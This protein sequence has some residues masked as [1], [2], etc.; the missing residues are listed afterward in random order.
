MGRRSRD[1]WT[2]GTQSPEDGEVPNVQWTRVPC[3]AVRRGPGG[4]SVIAGIVG[5]VG[6][7]VLGDVARHVFGARTRVL[8]SRLLGAGSGN[9]AYRVALSGQDLPLVFR[10]NRG[11]RRDDFEDEAA[12]YRLVAAATG[13]RVPQIVA[14]DRSRT[15]APTSYM[16]LEYLEGDD[17]AALCRPGNADTSAAEK[18]AIRGEVGRFYARLHALTRPATADESLASLLLGLAQFPVAVQAGYLTVDLEQVAACERVVRGDAAMRSATLSLCLAGG[19]L[20]FERRGGAYRLGFVLD[21][22]WAGFDNRLVDLSRHVGSWALDEPI[23]ALDAPVEVAPA[24]LRGDPFFTA[25]A[26]R[27]PVDYEGLCRLALYTHLSTWGLVAA[28]P[29]APEKKRWIRDH[30]LPVINR[31]IQLIASR[32]G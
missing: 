15:V 12:N 5:A 3:A 31:L 10:F 11:L 25:Y 29:A 20:Y 18:R 19:Q 13:I 32:E 23:W 2:C 8:A 24:D 7:G 26:E 28:E 6:E 21:L 16:V 30:K 14:I 22:E 9:V 27:A 17:W 1:E 4:Q